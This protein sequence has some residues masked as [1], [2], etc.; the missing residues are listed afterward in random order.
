MS[1]CAVEAPADAL[2]AAAREP[3]ST[4][5]LAGSSTRRL[6]HQG[7]DDRG[8]DA[9]ACPSGVR[10]DLALFSFNGSHWVSE[11][12]NC[13]NLEPVERRAIFNDFA[14][15]YCRRCLFSGAQIRGRPPSR[16]GRSASE[17]W[18]GSRCS[19]ARW[20]RQ[21]SYS[22]CGVFIRA[23]QHVDAWAP[24]NRAVLR[25]SILA[26]SRCDYSRSA[27]MGPVALPSVYLKNP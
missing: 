19:S 6:A 26:E 17:S 3:A 20:V 25:K 11:S 22:S 7:I 5:S 4:E 16:H 27:G 13:E 24:P 23:R 2:G 10:K 14:R 1:A 8:Q 18:M 15:G 9:S 12:R 21:G